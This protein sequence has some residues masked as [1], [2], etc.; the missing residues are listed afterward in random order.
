MFR[1][2]QMRPIQSFWQLQNRRRIYCQPAPVSLPSSDSE[3]KVGQI[4]IYTTRTKF[5]LEIYPRA[6]GSLS[7]YIPSLPFPLPPLSLHPWL[8]LTLL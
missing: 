5:T 8:L 7:L 2:L 6:W 1:R 4:P 3:S